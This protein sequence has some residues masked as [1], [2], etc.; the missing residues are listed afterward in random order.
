[1]NEIDLRDVVRLRAIPVAEN[2]REIGSRYEVE[3]A[4]GTVLSV[5]HS[6]YFGLWR[7]LPAAGARLRHLNLGLEMRCRGAEVAVGWPEGITKYG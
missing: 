7:A 1:M 2:G 6:R 3:T 4:A 5:A